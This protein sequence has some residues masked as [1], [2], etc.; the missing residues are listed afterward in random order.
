ME[1]ALVETF[2]REFHAETNKKTQVLAQGISDKKRKLEKLATRL[3]GLYDAIADGLRTPGLKSKILEMEAEVL[4]M[5]SDLDAAPS[6]APILHP[7]LA[8]LYRRQIKNLHEALNAQDS[9]TEAAEILRGIIE[10]INVTP[11]GRGSFE[12]DLTGDI[13][14]MIEFAESGTQTEK[15]A[16]KEAAIPDVYRSSVKV[17]AGVGFEPT[18]F[19]L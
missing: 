1:P 19:R 5:K 8:E 4:T 12:I 14:N 10:R 18:T 3:D 17:V 13:V 9:R 2:I 16:S 11:L 6:P 7:N 15:A